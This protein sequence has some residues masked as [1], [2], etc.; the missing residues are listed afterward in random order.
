MSKRELHL[1]EIIVNESVFPSVIRVWAKD[2]ENAI[3]IATIEYGKRKKW[4]VYETL[5]YTNKFTLKEI[6]GIYPIIA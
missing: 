5:L 2:E 4:K 1:F 3:R 6:E